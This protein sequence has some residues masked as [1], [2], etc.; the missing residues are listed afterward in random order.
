LELENAITTGS[1]LNRAELAK[2]FA[3][4]AD[5]LQQSVLNSDLPRSAKENFLHNLSSWP[6]RLE[7]IARNQTRFRGAKNGPAEEDQGEE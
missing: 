2:T 4:L 3:E 1:I 6:L 5:A 7:T